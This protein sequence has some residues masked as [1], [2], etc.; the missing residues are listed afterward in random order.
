[1][2]SV[3][4]GFGTVV[5]SY[6]ARSRGSGEPE[7]SISRVKDLQKFI[8][9]VEAFVQDHGESMCGD[10][11]GSGGSGAE[12]NRGGEMYERRVWE[13]REEF[14]YLLGNGDG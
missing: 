14:E 5:A 13:L 6:L 2:T 12:G 4:G 1:M 11:N 10:G 8:R 7:L 3:L 9:E